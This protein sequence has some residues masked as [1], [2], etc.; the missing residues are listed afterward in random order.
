MTSNPTI[1]EVFRRTAL[2]ITAMYLIWCSVSLSLMALGPVFVGNPWL[3]VLMF[4]LSL[5]IHLLLAVFITQLFMVYVDEALNAVPSVRAFLLALCA[6]LGFLVYGIMRDGTVKGGFIES[7]GTAN[8]IVLAC[9]VATWMTHPLT[10]PSELVPVCFVVALADL[11][12]V[13]AGPTRHLVEGLTLYYEKGMQ[14]PPPLADYILVKIGVPGYTVPVPLFG[15]S[16]WI[17]LVFLCSAMTRFGLSDSLTGSG[18]VSMKKN[19]RLSFYLPVT[20]LGLILALIVAQISARFLPALP[21][22]VA[23][24]LVY[25]LVRYPR[26]RHLNR[27]EWLLLSGFSSA[28]LVLLGLGMWFKFTL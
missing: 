11:F 28:M 12:S 21:F 19:R 7:L 14:G 2:P 26:V 16:D 3:D 18:I 6:A 9:L 22:M 8:L 23:V 15:V 5:I 4:P 20:V 1:R 25:A 17:I 10:R 27:R 13:F 24:F